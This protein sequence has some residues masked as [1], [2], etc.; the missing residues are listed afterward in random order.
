[1]CRAIRLL[2][3]SVIAASSSSGLVYL[4]T[5]SPCF[6]IPSTF[7]NSFLEPILTF[8]SLNFVLITIDSYQYFSP[9]DL[10]IPKHRIL[11][12]RYKRFI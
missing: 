3:K 6:L 2:F 12:V 8:V 1:M 9:G 4:V 5:G 7:A 10:I 11:I